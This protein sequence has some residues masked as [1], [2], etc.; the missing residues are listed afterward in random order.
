MKNKESKCDF[1]LF[2][3][4]RDQAD[5]FVKADDDTYMVIENL[6]YMLN[7][8]QPSEPIWFGCKFK[9]IVKP[10]G[11]MSGGAGKISKKYLVQSFYKIYLF[12]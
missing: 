9:V 2:G 8:Y 5:W 4:S 10:N 6:R 12:S 7:G 3:Y 11:Y 1:L